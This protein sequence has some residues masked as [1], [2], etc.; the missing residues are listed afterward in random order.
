MM[1]RSLP[2]ASQEARLVLYDAGGNASAVPKCEQLPLA[3]DCDLWLQL[4][5]L[6]SPFMKSRPINHL[7]EIDSTVSRYRIFRRQL[8]A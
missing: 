5:G 8:G 3:L 1:P 4:L 6:N 2:R 7:T